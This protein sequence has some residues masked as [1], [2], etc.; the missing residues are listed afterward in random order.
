MIPRLIVLLALG[1]CLDQKICAQNGIK[2][3][4]WAVPDTVVPQHSS[5]TILCSGPTGMTYMR[6]QRVESR[7]WDEKPPTGAKEVVN[8][9]FQKV[10]QFHARTYYCRYMKE[11]TW[12][13][14][15]D[16]LKLVVTGVFKGIPYLTAH[17]GPRVTLGGNVTLLCHSDHH[18]DSLHLYKD[19]R[20]ALGYFHQDRNTFLISPVTLTSEGIYTCY[21]SSRQNPLLWSLP[22]KPLDLVVTDPYGLEQGY[23]HVVIGVSAAVVFIFLFLLL[24]L[25]C[26]WYHAKHRAIDGET[27]NQVKYNSSS[28]SLDVQEENQ[29]ATIKDIQ[30]EEYEQMDT[31]VPKAEDP[32]E[33]TYAVLQQENLIRSVDVPSSCTLRD[34][35]QQPCVYATLTLPW[36]CLGKVIQAQK[37]PLPKPSL[38]AS[39]SALVPLGKSVIVQCRGPPGVDLYRLEKLSSGKYEDRAVLSIPVMRES[40]A[41]QYRCTYQ[42]GTVWSPSSDLLDL[43]A[44]GGFSKPSLSALPSSSVSQG[45]DVT[46]WCRTQFGF[47]RFALYKEGDPGPS[48]SPERWYQAEF[49][50]ITVTAAHSGTYR[51]YSFSSSFPYLW[52]HPSDPLVL[53]V[54][55]TSVTPSW[56]PTKRPTPV[57]GT[58]KNIAVFSTE[59]GSPTGLAHQYY[60]KGNL[61][62]ICLGAVILVLLVGIL[63]EDWHSRKKLLV[64][65]V[66]AVQRPLPPLP[67]TPKP[68][69]LGQRSTR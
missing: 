30:P 40:F 11:G 64:H 39:P 32:K 53:V 20:K 59:S 36:L 12:S 34:A 46:L 67:Q 21:G 8:F 68:H 14:Q 69:Q 27:K 2:P 13:R 54:T 41:G 65:R 43:V 9:S 60:T 33:V 45:G 44:I 3:S 24:F 48:K 38:Q 56:L 37:A 55:G 66:R 10:T 5:V 52:S 4:I 1:F 22:S 26:R 50:I 57:S 17:P 7:E 19:G 58:S 49:P 61:V 18:Y 6:L 23:S 63:V 29:Y 28:P 25:L 16:P 35:S 31:Q 42:N 62:R 47:D 51:C 15:S